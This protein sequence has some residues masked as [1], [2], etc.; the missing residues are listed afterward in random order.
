MANTL[1]TI[2]GLKRTLLKDV[3][4]LCQHKEECWNGPII[5]ILQ[6]LQ[7]QKIR[8]VFFG[9][10]LRSLLTARMYQPRRSLGRPRDIDLVVLG[11]SIDKLKQ[12]F[13]SRI[14][15]ETRFGGIQIRHGNWQFDLW[16][17]DK[18]WMLR[19]EKIEEI[20]FKNLPNTTFLNLE[21][22]AVDI[23]PSSSRQRRI[24]S[25]NDQFF[26]GLVSRTLEVNREE[27]PFPHLCVIRALIMASSLQFA[28]GPKLA[29][30]IARHG[31]DLNVP[32]F[33]KIQMSHYGEIREPGDKMRL[34]VQFIIDA[35]S[36]SE[37]N[38]VSLPFLKAYRQLTFWEEKD[39]PSLISK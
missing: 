15:R 8:S 30:Y 1:P 14:S 23:W 5:D 20:G 19:D 32:D 31:T 36:N 7:Q 16:P 4:H 12:E 3:D 2:E 29:H 22:I 13:R 37:H 25:G 24:Y 11:I 28:I 34:W 35:L 9:G 21:A 26:K 18:T 10:T 39:T 27:N 6:K 33:E 17:L 38:P